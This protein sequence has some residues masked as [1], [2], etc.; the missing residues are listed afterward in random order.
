MDAMSIDVDSVNTPANTATSIGTREACRR[1]NENNSLD[2]DETGVDALAIDVTAA[3]I[4]P[5]SNGG[6]PG[7]PGDDTG[8]IIAYGYKLNY[9]EASLTVEAQDSTF[10]LTA[11]NGSSTFNGS[12]PVPDTNGDNAFNSAALD[13]GSS[14][15]EQGSGVLD[16]LM[17][18]TDPAATTGTHFMTLTEPLHIDGGEQVYLPDALNNGQIAVNTGCPVALQESDLKISS[19][20]VAAPATAN[21]GT[22]F[23]VTAQATVHN[24]GPFGPVNA[25]TSFALNLPADCSAMPPG[26][27]SA[28]N[29]SIPVSS[30]QTIPGSP[31]SWSV[32]CTAVASHTISVSALSVLDDLA[33][34]DPNPDN[35]IGEGNAVTSISDNADIKITSVTVDTPATETVG[36][37]FFVRPSAVVHNNG[38]YQPVQAKATFTLTVPADCFVLPLS[39]PQTHG[40]ASVALS[41]PVTL[42][43]NTSLGLQLGWI[44]T[45]DDPGGH[46]FAVDV[47]LAF[48]QS[49]LTDLAPGNNMMTGN[50]S[51]NFL[52]GICGADPTPDGSVLQQPSPLLLNLIQNLS[53]MVDGTPT[54]PQGQEFQLDCNMTMDLSDNQGAPIDDCKTDLLTEVPCSMSLTA[55]FNEPGGVPPNTPT[56]RLNPVPVFF[57]PPEFDW[58][59]DLEVPNGTSVGSG[60]FEVRTDGGLTPFGI[61][62]VVDAL[63]PLA[64]AVE[65]G[66]LPNVPDSNDSDDL[67]NPN[68]WPNDLNA[69]RD[70]VINAFNLLPPPPPPLPPLPPAVSVHGRVIVHLNAPG[71]AEITLNIVIFRVD[72]ALIRAATGADF[73]IVGFP[74]DALG[75]DPAGPGGGD[76]DADDAASFPLVTCAPNLYRFSFNGAAGSVAYI[77]CT[78]PSSPMGWALMDPDAVNW[79]GDQGPRS[80]VSTCSLDLDNDGLT[81]Q[82]ETYYGTNNLMPDTDGDTILDGPDNCKLT[83]NTNQAN[84]D[85]DDLGDACDPDVDGDGVN[86]G[87][88]LCPGT[89]LLAPV[90]PE[91]CSAAQVDPDG[92][93]ICSP[94]A[95]SAGPAPGCSGS[96]NCPLDANP[97]QADLDG[98][99]KGDACDADDENDGV[100]DLDEISCGSEPMNGTRRP[101]RIDGAFTGVDDDGDTQIDEALPPAAL[102]FDCDGDGYTGA[103]ENG[104]YAPNVLGDQDPC[105]TN[106]FPATSPPSPIGWPS[107][108]R[109]EDSFSA[110]KVNIVDLGTFVVPIRRINTNIGATLGGAR[111]DLFPGAGIFDHDINIQDMGAVITAKTGFPPMLLG[112]RAFNA[113]CPWP[114]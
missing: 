111:W 109:G 26:P 53:A 67:T 108:L 85:G 18:A 42:D 1:I 38:P 50:G 17:I 76:P 65:G 31:L 55:T 95:P 103:K 66:I 3:G 104:L 64:Q 81:D 52:V 51:T 19:V 70:F 14:T 63:F 39:G 8:G 25:D 107:D 88:D 75:P 78:Q 43:T 87:A 27:Q 59:A 33:A 71:L 92:D 73:L 16:R 79:A 112:G 94:G 20:S 90:D 28:E 96:D 105:G 4:P 11:N 15:P 60:A 49:N 61:P 24:N 69:E 30:P 21:P 106:S 34:I 2:A 47:V 36:T 99:G 22:P 45:C 86:N 32:T 100:D 12:D 10:L 80:D 82:E 44:V 89:A 46:N 5:Y 37:G 101:E 62:C 98:D 68:V 58:A 23:T 84:Y 9:P 35:N 56:T 102:A 113:N 93:G 57:I 54:V 74:G 114:Q 72:D 41:T 110:N 13:V 40:G 6:T 48:D 77:A 29:V 97:S 7:D 91:G 83:P